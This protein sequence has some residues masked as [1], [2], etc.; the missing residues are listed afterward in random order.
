MRF[1]TLCQVLR[2]ITNVIFQVENVYTNWQLSYLWS[3]ISFDDNISV[4]NSEPLKYLPFSRK[5]TKRVCV[6]R[7]DSITDALLWWKLPA[8]FKHLSVIHTSPPSDHDQSLRL[9]LNLVV[10][11]CGTNKFCVLKFTVA[12]ATHFKLE[13][14]V[15][16]YKSYIESVRQQRSWLRTV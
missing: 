9:P 4:K 13:H 15:R 5:F 2:M 14:F 12:F 7:T 10:P 8:H 6:V 3:F 11:V 16:E 1:K